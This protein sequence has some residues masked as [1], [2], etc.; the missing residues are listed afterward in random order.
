MF[1]WFLIAVTL[2]AAVVGLVIGSLNPDTV[3]LE[4]LVIS[5]RL[6]L[7]ALVVAGLAVG[8]LTGLLLSWLLFILPGRLG[9]PSTKRNNKG[10]HLAD[11]P[12]G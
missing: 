10:K 6:P 8:A 1:R 4:L 11:Q 2:A 5:L 3:E 12:D 7:G 9:A